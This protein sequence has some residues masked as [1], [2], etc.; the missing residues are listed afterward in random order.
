MRTGLASNARRTN[1][2]PIRSLPSCKQRREKSGF[3]ENSENAQEWRTELAGLLVEAEMRIGN[4]QQAGDLLK[5][6][7]ER[8]GTS[9]ASLEQLAN[10][11]RWLNRHKIAFE[12]R[13]RIARIRHVQTVHADLARDYDERG[14]SELARKHRAMARM[15]AG[16]VNFRQNLISA[17]RGD[18]QQAVQL[19]QELPNAWYYLAECHRL[20]GLTAKAVQ[21]YRNCL[22]ADANHGRARSRLSQLIK[23]TGKTN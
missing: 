19:D 3:I 13:K 20:Q 14:K 2:R 8:E 15:T 21:A 16:I 5:Q 10:S 11:E 1:C 17:A 4:A 18:L 7:M 23:T 22:K 12:L 9:T 6:I